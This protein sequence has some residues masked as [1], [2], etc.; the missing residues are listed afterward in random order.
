MLISSDEG[1]T[2][3]L[4]EL[5]ERGIIHRDISFGNTLRGPIGSHIKG[6]LID[7]DMAAEMQ[8]LIDGICNVRDFRTVSCLC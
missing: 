4:F 8:N 5:L 1:L 6:I 7:L 3:A 2:L